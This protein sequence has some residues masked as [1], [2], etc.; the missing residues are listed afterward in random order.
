MTAPSSADVFALIA[1]ELQ[2]RPGLTIQQYRQ[3]AQEPFVC[4]A[5]IYLQR[6]R[7]QL[8]VAGTKYELTRLDGDGV[9]FRSGSGTRFEFTADGLTLRQGGIFCYGEGQLLGQDHFLR[10]KYFPDAVSELIQPMQGAH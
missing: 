8:P 10:G 7:E 3:Q 2:R 9:A 1:E 6:I 4:L 5:P